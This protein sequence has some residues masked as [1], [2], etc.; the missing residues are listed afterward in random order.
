MSPVICHVGSANPVKVNAAGQ[1][2]QRVLNVPVTPQAHQVN[3]GVPDQPMTA[4]ETR[5]GAVNRVQA[6]LDELTPDKTSAD[7]FMAFEGGVEMTCDGPVTFAY[8]AIYHGDEW[9]VTRS[10]SLP[11]PPV[12]YQALS[13]GQELGDVMDRLF[14]TTNIKQQGGAIGLLTNHLATR[15]SVYELAVILAMARFNHP[16]LFKS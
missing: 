3:S 10:S 1:T 6:M 11:L 9:S 15:Q 5:A 2:L 16:A 14:N 8:V 12:I 4:Q 7:W 13:E